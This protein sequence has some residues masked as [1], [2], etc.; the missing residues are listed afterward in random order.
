MDLSLKV[1]SAEKEEKEIQVKMDIVKLQNTPGIQSNVTFK[2]IVLSIQ[3]LFC[4]MVYCV[5]ASIWLS[6]FIVNYNT[7]R[8]N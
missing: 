8:T 3:M 2:R 6:C 1:L 7:N 4:F 5:H